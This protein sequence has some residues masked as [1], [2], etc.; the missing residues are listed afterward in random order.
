[1]ATVAGPLAIEP[2]PRMAEASVVEGMLKFPDLTLLLEDVTTHRP[3]LMQ[4][5]GDDRLYADDRIIVTG[6]RLLIKDLAT[7]NPH[8]VK[9]VLAHFPHLEVGVLATSADH[10]RAALDAVLTCTDRVLLMQAQ[11]DGSWEYRVCPAK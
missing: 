8:Q 4:M 1:M 7:C 2:W 11:P 3:W 9:L 6:T 5:L 10:P